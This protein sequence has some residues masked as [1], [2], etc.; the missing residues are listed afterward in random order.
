MVKVR[1]LSESEQVATEHLW[2]TGISYTQIGKQIG[3]SKSAAFKVLK[4]LKE[5]ALRIKSEDVAIQENFWREENELYAE[6]HDWDFQV[7]VK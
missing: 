2:L 6:F 3:Y 4:N 5:Q 1:Q 7:W